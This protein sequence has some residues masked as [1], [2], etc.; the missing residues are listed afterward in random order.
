MRA[1]ESNGGNVF[2]K[3]STAFYA[4]IARTRGACL[5]GPGG[6]A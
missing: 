2:S 4:G 5:G 1:V 6:A 3:D